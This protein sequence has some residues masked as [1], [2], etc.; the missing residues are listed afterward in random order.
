M[1]DRDFLESQQLGGRGLSVIRSP[2]LWWAPPHLPT[3][4]LRGNL[5]RFL[6]GMGW[7]LVGH[8]SPPKHPKSLSSPGQI[9]MLSLPQSGHPAPAPEPSTLPQFCLSLL[10][11][12]LS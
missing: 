3:D 5:V 11:G 7:L 2:Q 4:A 8:L 6:D 9:A 10:S 1:K 12:F